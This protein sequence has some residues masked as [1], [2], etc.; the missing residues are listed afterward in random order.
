MSDPDVD[1]EGAVSQLS[2]TQADPEKPPPTYYH[3]ENN[4]LFSPTRPLQIV[5]DV[6]ENMALQMRIQGYTFPQIAEE[7]GLSGKGAARKCVMRA[8]EEIH[9]DT[10]EKARELRDITLQR[11]D[12]MLTVYFPAAMY[13]DPQA[14][15]VV[16]RIEKSR[17]DLLGL[18]APTVISNEDGDTM[19]II[20]RTDIDMDE[21]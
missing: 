5:S 20:K 9:G 12:S 3:I 11:L 21:L 13:G 16:L 6:R 15:A 14:A 1:S 18:D 10:R 7:L 2:L 17:R 8:L 4:I 19:A